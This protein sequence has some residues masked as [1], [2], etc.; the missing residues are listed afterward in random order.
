M[1]L[2]FISGVFI[3]RVLGAEDFGLYGI[4]I[5]MAAILAIPSQSGF[6][7]LIIKE[8]AS[9]T[10]NTSNSYAR[11][12]RSWAAKRSFIISM[13][14]ASFAI[15][16]FLSSST[17]SDNRTIYILS[18][19]S[20]V[21][22]GQ[23]ISSYSYL[24]GVGKTEMAQVVEV[25]VYPFVFLVGC[26]IVW[27]LDDF[28]L[29]IAMVLR[30]IAL[31]FVSWSGFVL[32]RKRVTGSGAINAVGK[33]KDIDSK[34]LKRLLIPFVF[35]DGIRVAQAHL[36][37]LIISAFLTASDAGQFKVA[38]SLILFIQL[39]ATVLITILSPEIS[40]LY[41]TDL[42]SMKQKVK[43]ATQ[44]Y[45]LITFVAFVAVY[46]ISLDLIVFMFGVQ[47]AFSSSILV[48]VSL[49][50]F[51]SSFF[52]FGDVILNMV[53]QGKVVLK[54]SIFTLIIT[55]FISVLA[56]KAYGLTGAA[57]SFG[58]TMLMQRIFFHIAARRVLI[59][60]DE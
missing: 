60:N 18:A 27:R 24:K 52:G 9:V 10:E 40:R 2:T 19:L 49:F 38:Q 46:F 44:V 43:N 16:Y 56:M 14:I 17:Y 39:P 34:R 47:Y 28:S 7:N 3:A 57:Y 23:N 54:I 37:L 4:V 11:Q 59:N 50:I 20:V 30:C 15:V 53:G 36:F 21:I 6:G 8:V 33:T 29:E 25:L 1:S 26:F 55:V 32:I 31:L 58:T 51:L 42:S 35:S 22:M 12:V 5:S 13:L 41:E 48:I 45:T